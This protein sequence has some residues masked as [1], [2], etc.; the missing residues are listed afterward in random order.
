[1]NTNF[2]ARSGKNELWDEI[3]STNDRAIQL[4]REGAAEGIMVLARQQTGG[5]GRQGRAWVSPKDSGIFI[6]FVL[7]PT[8]DPA[9][10]PLISFAGGVAAAQ[11]IERVTGLRI[12]LKWVNDLIYG[13]KKLGGILAEMPGS[14]ANTEK[15]GSGWILPPAVILGLG[16]NLSLTNDD[17]TEDLLGKVVSLDHLLGTS[18]D[19]DHLV[20]ELCSRLED[21][22][23]HLRHSG[24]ELV[25]D[26]WKNY[27][28]TLG[29]RIRTRVQDE[30][31]EGV[32]EDLNESGALILR[33]DNGENRLL[34]AGE[35]TIRLEDGRYA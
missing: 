3:A 34:H 32:A 13:G 18:I 9:V 11:A 26:E 23:N 14:Q 2:I 31:L 21:Q 19:A 4:A 20:S 5:R 8:L 12:G 25:L 24:H 35:I 10:L 28:Q 30:D 7:R 33:L 29:K 17:V 16:I 1:L 15:A 6:S 22:Y 27:S